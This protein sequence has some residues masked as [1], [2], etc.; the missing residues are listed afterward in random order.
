MNE[1]LSKQMISA[2]IKL[3]LKSGNSEELLTSLAEVVAECISANNLLM[4]KQLAVVL[5]NN[6]Y[7]YAVLFQILQ[8]VTDSF[9]DVYS[10]ELN[11]NQ[12]RKNAVDILEKDWPEIKAKIV[13][14]LSLSKQINEIFEK[15]DDRKTE[16]SP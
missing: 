12:L 11:L 3:K 5:E 14:E 8:L 15:N 1:Y 2:Q 4:G 10:I 9:R 13:E 6:I 16:N 7:N